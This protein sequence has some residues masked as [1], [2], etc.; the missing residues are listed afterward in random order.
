[1]SD[2]THTRAGRPS[3]RP[4]VTLYE[5]DDVRVTLNWLTVDRQRYQIRELRNLRTARGDRRPVGAHMFIP[6]AGLMVAFVAVTQCLAMDVWASLAGG[7]A[8]PTAIIAFAMANRPQACE[9]WA[10]YR[11]LTVQLLWLDDREQFN[12]ICRALTRAKERTG[13]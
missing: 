6:A 4:D 1:M 10:D 5:R 7:A 12:Q 8:L 11:G 13:C 9:L 2:G 3:A